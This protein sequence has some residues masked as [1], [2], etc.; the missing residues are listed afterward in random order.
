MSRQPKK[1]PKV[2]P[3]GNTAVQDPPETDR[4]TPTA[5]PLKAKRDTVPKQDTFFGRI[6][7]VQKDDWGT[8]AKIKAYRLEPIIDRLRG[9]ENK[10][11]TIYHEPI[12]E[13]KMKIDHGS[14]RTVFTSRTKSRQGW[15]RKSIPSNSTSWT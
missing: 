11:I 4:S 6:A 14:G 7:R 8:R 15:T 12:T 1:G 13:E 10:Y 2:Q 9:S 3:I 5:P